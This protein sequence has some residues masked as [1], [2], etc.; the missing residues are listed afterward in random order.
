MSQPSIVMTEGEANVARLAGINQIFQ[1]ALTSENEQTLVLACLAIARTI[2]QSQFGFI[3]DLIEAGPEELTS[4]GPRWDACAISGSDG[5]RAAPGS[6]AIHGDSGR[7]ML[8]GQSWFTNEP[9]SHCGSFELPGNYPP[10]TAFLGVPLLRQGRF[11]GLLAV[12]NR[13]GGYRQVEQASLEALAPSIV[14]TLMRNRAEAKL[15]L[16]AA[17]L[18][19]ANANLLQSRHDIIKVM[20]DAVIAR[21]QAE[22]LSLELQREVT[23]RKQADEDLRR[24]HAQL[25]AIHDD[26]AIFNNVAVGRELRMIE[27]KTEINA[28]CAAVGRPRRYPLEFDEEEPR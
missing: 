24:N 9:A 23:E 21:R 2:T 8:D 13:A 5:H 20:Q 17:E 11:I 6:F 1:A 4:G 18:Q 7:V 27:L 26:L 25:Q 28:L 3:G 16:F 19:A 12:C 15:R 10:L 14:A 22:A